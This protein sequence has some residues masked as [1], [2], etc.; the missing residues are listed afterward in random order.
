MNENVGLILGMA[1]YEI[2]EFS[3]VNLMA[4]SSLNDGSMIIIPGHAPTTA[5]SSRYMLYFL[6]G[7]F[8]VKSHILPS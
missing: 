2:D 4:I 1:N 5:N 3:Q 8:G 6:V 7:R